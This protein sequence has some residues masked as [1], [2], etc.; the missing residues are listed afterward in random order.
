MNPLKC[1]FLL[2]WLLIS[3]V[4]ITGCSTV[5]P[6]ENP[7]AQASFDENEANSGIV[8][9]Y[10]GVYGDLEG[11]IITPRARARYNALIE[12]LG[13]IWS[14]AISADYGVSPITEGLHAGRFLMTI[15]AMDKFKVMR[16][17]AALG[18]ATKK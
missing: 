5:T 13:T 16:A 15:E 14:P 12:E 11:Y 18:T 4:A 7:A 1:H 6:S 17:R 8:T 10:V 9:V 2:A 3:G